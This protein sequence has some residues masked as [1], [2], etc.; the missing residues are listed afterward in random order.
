MLVCLPLLLGLW[1]A[2]SPPAALHITEAWPHGPTN[3]EVSGDSSF[4]FNIESIKEYR[5]KSA[6][7]VIINESSHEL[8]MVCPGIGS[9][10][11]ALII[12]ERAFER[13]YDW[14]DLKERVK[15]MTSNKIERL[16]EA[17][18]RLNADDPQKYP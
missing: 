17:G 18:V 10:T 4:D 12:K 9:R 11:A 8:L 1:P 15:G 14:R 5:S 3:V 7:Q 16:Q 6:D 13:F 2:L